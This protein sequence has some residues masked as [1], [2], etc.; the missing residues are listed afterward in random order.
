[1]RIRSRIER[2]ED[3]MLPLPAA[4]PLHL[5]IQA[6]DSEGKVVTSTIFEAP[7]GAPWGCP[8][9]PPLANDS[10]AARKVRLMNQRET[11]GA[12]G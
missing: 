3:E 6:V 12:T 8:Y 1:M 11:P 5:H 9:K 2:L 4:P 7:H 10:V